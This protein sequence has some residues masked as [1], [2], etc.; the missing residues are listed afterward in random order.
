MFSLRKWVTQIARETADATAK[1]ERESYAKECAAEPVNID[2]ELD[3]GIILLYARE[4]RL[5][6]VLEWKKKAV[7][8]QEEF[9]TE[10]RAEEEVF[11]VDGSC[12]YRM[13]RIG[14]SSPVA[15]AMRRAI[16]EAN[17][18]ITDAVQKSATAALKAAKKAANA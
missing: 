5:L 13:G 11:Y 1:A 12:G 4:N 7:A 18:E 14:S 6:P 3:D 15:V 9:E 10:A 17:V 8:W 16:L 2:S